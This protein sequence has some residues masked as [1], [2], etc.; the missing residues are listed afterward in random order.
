MPINFGKRIAGLRVAAGAGRGVPMGKKPSGLVATLLVVLLAGAASALAADAVEKA[1]GYIAEGAHKAAFIELKNALQQDPGNPE[2]RLVLGELYLKVKDGASAEKELR[3]AEDLGVDP[4]RWRLNLVEAMILQ[5]KLDE[6]LAR[7]DGFGIL[8]PEEQSRAMA[9]R[10]RSSLGLGRHQE[11]ELQFDEA[12]AVDADN[13]E[14]ILGKVMVRLAQ[15]NKAAATAAADE[16]LARFPDN[17]EALLVRAELH[18]SAGENDL[19][20]QRFDR[21]LQADPIHLRALL[22]RA[23]TRVAMGSFD[24]AAA[25]LA[26]VDAIRKDL[27]VTLYLRAVIAFK[28]EKL[29]QARE[30]LQLVLLAQPD[31]L[32]SQYLMGIISY[33]TGELQ[34]AEEYLSQVARQVPG[35]PQVAKLLGATRIKLR[36]PERA[37]EVLQ[38]LVEAVGDAQMMALLGSAYAM[39]GDQVQGQEWLAR[40]VEVSPD[41]AT[42]RTQLALSMLAGGETEKA[43]GEL[44]SAVDLGQDVLQADVLLV[45]AHIKERRFEKAIEAS[46]AL[47]ERNPD[48]PI[49]Y[50]LT[51]LAFLAK[52]E[53]EQARQRFAKALEVDPDFVTGY[54]N[55]ARIDTSEGDLAA[56][57]QRFASVLAKQPRHMTAMLGM[58][59]LAER[60]QDLDGMVSWLE[61]AQEADPQ[62]TEPGLLLTKYYLI[63][64]DAEQALSVASIMAQRF[65]DNIQVLAMLAQ[66]Q[67]LAGATTAHI[68]TL[69]RIAGLRPED[70]RVH[71]Q[72]GRAKWRAEDMYGARYALNRAIALDPDFIE[73]KAALA[74]LEI[75]DGN[76]EE[77]LRLAEQMQKD[78]PDKAVGYQIEGAYYLSEDQGAAAVKALEKAYAIEKTR[79]LALLLARAHMRADQREQAIGVL[80]AWL[81]EQPDDGEALRLLAMAYQVEG[82]KADAIGVYEKLA[83]T[84][85]EESVILNNLAWLYHEQ[86]DPRALDIA[87]KA[88]DLNPEKP[89]VADT[90]GWVL[91]QQAGKVHEGLSILQQAYVAFPTHKEI[92]YHVAVGLARA[93]RKDESIKVLQGLLREGED[94][95]QADD[96]KTLLLELEKP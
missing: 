81:Q 5:G 41:V 95:P 15:Q 40:A 38:P 14:A 37:I 8:T 51:G 4:V 45:L 34:I 26:R 39:Q 63:E 3:R 11:A 96:A 53:N 10:G 32:Q 50:N 64:R 94:F 49:A 52:G 67:E 16:M 85:P 84:A 78:Y 93:D 75:Q 79:A 22:G 69:D 73:A 28:G 36:E 59:A 24:E 47:E 92:G 83:Q 6:A 62:A 31:H 20:L 42:I 70:A 21:I 54:L 18:R 55:L 13:Q 86:G 74:G 90:Y 17:P 25:D 72:V 57:E 35:N 48:S 9:L 80:A 44:E 33:L 30:Q 76:G 56:A 91:L 7:L 29:D 71:Y 68:G 82:R 46:R 58:A 12:I 61:K 66:A 88:Y 27:P 1:R 65:P 19:A 87:K 2:A 89:E 77:A 23:T 60:R 43:I